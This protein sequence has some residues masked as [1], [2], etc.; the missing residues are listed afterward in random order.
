[1]KFSKIPYIEF[2]SFK[3]VRNQFDVSSS[4]YGDSVT[5]NIKFQDGDG[6]LGIANDDTSSN[7]DNYLIDIYSMENGVYQKLNFDPSFDG[8]F[9]KLTTDNTVGPIDGTLSRSIFIYQLSP[10]HPN[11]TLRF[12]IK[13]LDRAQNE[14]NTITTPY[15]VVWQ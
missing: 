3:I 15:I 2:K 5:I 1:M 9:P 10:I 8:Q 7:G 4:A 13:I 6:D 14:S 11:D 12:D